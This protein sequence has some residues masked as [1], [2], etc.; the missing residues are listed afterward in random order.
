MRFI[1]SCPVCKYDAVGFTVDTQDI[2][3]NLV[4]INYVAK[5]WNVSVETLHKWDANGALHGICFRIGKNRYFDKQVIDTFKKKITVW[6]KK[7][8]LDLLKR[9]NSR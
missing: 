8:T 2:V 3:N 6:N 7:M 4:D 1:A 9:L 5:N